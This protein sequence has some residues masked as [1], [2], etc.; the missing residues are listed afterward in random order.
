MRPK[1]SALLAAS[2]LLFACAGTYTLK[3]GEPTALVRFKVL[4]DQPTYF[5]H[6]PEPLCPESTDKRLA[7]F[8]PILGEQSSEV[9]M[10]GSTGV[11]SR[12]V[13]ERAVSAG[14]PLYML[15]SSQRFSTPY[16]PGY[17]CSVGLRVV[18]EPGLQYE[19]IYELDQRS[20]TVR[21]WQLTQDGQ[22]V[23]RSVPQDLKF[24][25]VRSTKDFC[26]K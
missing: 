15:A 22:E 3:E 16:S 2:L 6:V 4:G 8:I 18:L 26:G 25:P 1:L 7:A 11:P 19:V 5:R 14:K 17:S 9:R 12:Y 13:Y 20:C 24:F 23:S 21:M 10:I